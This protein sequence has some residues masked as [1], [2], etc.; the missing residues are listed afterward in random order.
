MPQGNVIV[1]S[2]LGPSLLAVLPVAYKIPTKSHLVRF[3]SLATEV[4]TF[5]WKLSLTAF[6]LR[7]TMYV[8]V[9]NLSRACLGCVI[10]LIVSGEDFRLVLRDLCNGVR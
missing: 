2:S 3:D 8:Y 1:P 5:S 7:D 9:L 4:V 6:R 10:L